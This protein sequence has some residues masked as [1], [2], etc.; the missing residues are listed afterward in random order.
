MPL[1]HLRAVHFFCG[2][3]TTLLSMALPI[4]FLVGRQVRYRLIIHGGGSRDNYMTDLKQYGLK[5]E[6][7]SRRIIGGGFDDSDLIPLLMELES[8]SSE[9]RTSEDAVEN[10][11]GKVV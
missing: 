6:F 9:L 3:S 1:V 8:S 7:L 11:T 2:R 10:L 5:A 4:K